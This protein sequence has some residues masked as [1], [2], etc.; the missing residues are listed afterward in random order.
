MRQR[1][2]R[3]IAGFVAI[4]AVFT[5]WGCQDPSGGIIE[6]ANPEPAMIQGSVLLSEPMS[7]SVENSR[8]A[9]YKDLAAL[10]QRSPCDIVETDA[11]GAFEFCELR[12]EGYYLDAWKDNDG[13][14]LVTSG[15]F[16]FVHR[17]GNSCACLLHLTAGKVTNVQ[18]EMEVVP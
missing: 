10:E 18:A 12:C 8:V 14:G 13:N 5:L 15:D 11:T 1:M 4:L 2:I 7:G 16:Y 6:P 9:I 3:R 17:D